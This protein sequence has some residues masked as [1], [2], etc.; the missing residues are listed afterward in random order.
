VLGIG[1]E[2][3]VQ[4]IQ[5]DEPASE[6]RRQLDEFHQIAKVADAPVG[7]RPQRVEL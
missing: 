4:R 6:R 2:E 3:R 1:R 7:G 5:S